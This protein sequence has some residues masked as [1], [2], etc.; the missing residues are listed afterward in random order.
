M[1][2]TKCKKDLKLIHKII[3]RAMNMDIFSGVDRL[4]ME[5]DISACH[6]NGN[7][8]DLQR[9]LD[10]DDFN[11]LHD[12]GGI[13]GHLN[14]KTGKLTDCFRPRCSKPQHYKRGAV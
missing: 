2:F 8:L 13:R 7:P 11:F 10:A 9:L 14:R 4:D 5:M 12:V 3:A 1:K 6:A